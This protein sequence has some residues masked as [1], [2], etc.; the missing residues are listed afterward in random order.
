MF[1]KLADHYR[2]AIYGD[3]IILLDLASDKYRS[4]SA[5]ASQIFLQLLAAQQQAKSASLESNNKE[6]LQIKS[7]LLTSGII[8]KTMAPVHTV[9]NGPL[10]S[11]GI[12]DYSWS[13]QQPQ[14]GTLKILKRDFLYC[15]LLLIRV[16]IIVKKQGVKGAIDLLNK[17]A[18][19][20]S[21]EEAPLKVESLQYIIAS[22]EQAGR[23]YWKKTMCLAWAT[24]LA[25]LCL[26]KGWNVQLAIGIQLHPFLAHAWVEYKGKVL[27]DR[28]DV[29]EY[30]A[31]FLREPCFTSPEP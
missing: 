15:L 14:L 24:S 23:V 10:K 13:L 3:L 9:I 28:Q 12:K 22:L 20:Y 26:K 8:E 16:G 4:L 30:L 5:N 25:Y 7:E 29:N 17:Q 11:G 18:H 21:N 19:H 6:V 27:G 1:F 31:V 2:A